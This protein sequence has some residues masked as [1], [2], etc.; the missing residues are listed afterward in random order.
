MNSTLTSSAA[1]AAAPT[2]ADAT[3]TAGLVL[4][5]A[6]LAMGL[7]A[8]L[9]YAY[10]CSVMPGLHGASDRTALE[11]MQR[12]NVAILNPAFFATFLGAPLAGAAALYLEHR[13]GADRELTRSILA[14]LGCYAVVLAVTSAVNVPLNDD[15]A[16]L[17]VAKATASDL[18]GMRD[19]FQTTWVVGNLVRTVA[20]VGAFGCFAKALLAHGRGA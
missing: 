15:L 12:I 10:S 14:G 16:A 1:T 5:G 3:R 7:V 17:D 13:A 2:V 6:V 19:H 9:F 18:A 20:C 8:G 4:G 11:A